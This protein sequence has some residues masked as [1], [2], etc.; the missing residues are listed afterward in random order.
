MLNYYCDAVVLPNTEA[1]K[2]ILC[3]YVHS[4]YGLVNSA[5]CI[6]PMSDHCC[7]WLQP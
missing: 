4:L 1:E 6:P 5:G 3:L 2:E 7:D